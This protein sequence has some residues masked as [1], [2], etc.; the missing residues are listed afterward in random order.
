MYLKTHPF[1]TILYTRN[2]ENHSWANSWEIEA[3]GMLHFVYSSPSLH[4]LPSSDT[5][6]GFGK[7]LR[8]GILNKGNWDTYKSIYNLPSL[9]F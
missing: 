3:G 8:F 1:K 4:F 2:P 9:S 6:L 7:A 5:S